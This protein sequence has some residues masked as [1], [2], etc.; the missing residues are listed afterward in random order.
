MAPPRYHARYDSAPPTVLK[1]VGADTRKLS[2]TTLLTFP[3]VD[4][5]GDYVE[6]S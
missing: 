4:L 1:A 6:P 2:Y 3:V 5:D